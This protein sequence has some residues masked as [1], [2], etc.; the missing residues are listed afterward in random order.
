M[1]HRFV[2]SFICAVFLLME[3]GCSSGAAGCGGGYLDEYHNDENMTLYITGASPSPFYNDSISFTLLSPE[4]SSYHQIDPYPHKGSSNEF[5]LFINYNEMVFLVTKKPV[6]YDTL[7]VRYEVKPFYYTGDVCND[8]S[9]YPKAKVTACY[10]KNH[11]FS[12]TGYQ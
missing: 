12:V 2:L 8:P 4:N 9:Y 10:T 1:L 5:P 11:L 3:S 7:T 6:G